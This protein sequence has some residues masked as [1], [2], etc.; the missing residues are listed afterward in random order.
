MRVSIASV[1]DMMIGTD[2]PQNH[3]PDD[4]G[5]SFLQDVT[6]LI[7]AADIAFGNLEGVLIDGGT[8]GKKC[9]NPKACYLFRSPTRYA[10]HFKNAGFDVLSLANNHARDFGEEGRSSSMEAIQAR[11][12]HHSGRVGDFASLTVGDSNVAFLAFAVTKNSNMMLDYKLAFASVARFSASHDIVVV[13]F[14][15]GAEGVDVTH[16]PF[17][18]EEYYDEP[19][20]DVVWF[21]RG[22]VDAGAD[23][24]IGH[25]PHVVRGMER[26]KERLIAYSLGNFATYYGISVAGIK[27][28]A[29][30]LTVT[31]DGNGVFVE[32]QI[33]STVQQ[34]P[35]GPSLDEKQK[36]LNLI[37]G[38]SIDDFDSPGLLFNP[39]GKIVATERAPFEAH[40]LVVTP[41]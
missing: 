10:D 34:R 18:E 29:P 20:G 37:R 31:L 1:G 17:A 5:A 6:P 4:D 24:V 8:P 2:Y 36:A 25:G 16:I 38:L 35:A 19:R 7:S 12:M 3:L 26:Y 30:I 39:D 22:V 9:S 14:H 40:E 11:G 32:G 15:G 13:S 28:I 33:T 27:G 41:D 21:A 23:L